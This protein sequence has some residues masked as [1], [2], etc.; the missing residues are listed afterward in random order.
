[1]DGREFDGARIVVQHGRGHRPNGPK[2]TSRR[3]DHRVI[4]EGLDSRTSWQ[5]LKVLY[6]DVFF[7]NGRRWGESMSVVEYL[8][9]DDMKSA[10]RVLDDTRLGGKYIRVKE[11]RGGLP[12]LA[13]F[14]E[15][16]GRD[17][18]SRSRSRSRRSRS[19]S[20]SP[21][22]RR[23]SRDRRSPSPDDRDRGRRRER[24]YSRSRSPAR[25]SRSRS[26]YSR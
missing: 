13:G 7:R 19:E 23:R 6:S 26:R 12:N 8:S 21:P 22:R 5:D 1:M 20:R 2:F 15:N 25:R 18:R 9:R 17:S 4:V 24:D 3:T 16:A 10:I 11:V 14:R